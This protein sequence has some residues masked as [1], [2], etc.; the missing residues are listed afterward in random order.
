VVGQFDGR[1]IFSVGDRFDY[2]GEVW[3]LIEVR[4]D[5]ERVVLRRCADYRADS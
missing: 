1:D 2:L 4:A 3:V 5:S